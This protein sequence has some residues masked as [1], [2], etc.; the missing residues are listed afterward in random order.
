MVGTGAGEVRANA[1]CRNPGAGITAGRTQ[2][3][4]EKSVDITADFSELVKH[5]P[6]VV[7]GWSRASTLTRWV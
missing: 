3:A 7:V 2:A 4:A 6:S 5:V 1:I